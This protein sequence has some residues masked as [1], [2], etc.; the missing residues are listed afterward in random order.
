MTFG[1]SAGVEP[2]ETHG[3][4]H[5]R[6]KRRYGLWFFWTF[7]LENIGEAVTFINRSHSYIKLTFLRG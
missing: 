5:H 4:E 1:H 7:F 6:V 2:Y 3:G